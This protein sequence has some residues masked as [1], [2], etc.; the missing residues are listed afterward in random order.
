M[1]TR[2]HSDHEGTSWVVQAPVTATA[3]P[4]ET[5]LASRRDQGCNIVYC[6]RR[7]IR[8]RTQVED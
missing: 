1:D 8:D 4:E 2:T 7:D 6:T 3:P 5:V